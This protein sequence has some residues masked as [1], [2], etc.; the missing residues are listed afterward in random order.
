[1]HLCQSVSL[2]SSQRILPPL[3]FQLLDNSNQQESILFPFLLSL[4]SSAASWWVLQPSH[5]VKSGAGKTALLCAAENSHRERAPHLRWDW[6]QALCG[7][8]WEPNAPAERGSAAPLAHGTEEM[9][10]S[11]TRLQGLLKAHSTK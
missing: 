7:H 6:E 10:A 11:G 9:A 3:C 4:T 1:M 2:A 5:G 8:L